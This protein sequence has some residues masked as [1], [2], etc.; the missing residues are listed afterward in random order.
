M[1]CEEFSVIEHFDKG[2]SLIEEERFGYQSVHYLIKLDNVRIS[3][4][5]YQRFEN[6]KVEVQ[7]RTILQHA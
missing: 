7:V 3:L 5:E 2:E 6:A 1:L 4:P